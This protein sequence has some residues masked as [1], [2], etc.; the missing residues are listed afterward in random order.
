MPQA[1]RL[2]QAAP[3]ASPN[4]AFEGPF[5]RAV[6]LSPGAFGAAGENRARAA[7]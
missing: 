5:L 4:R 3:G 7:A 1:I 6:R 2:S